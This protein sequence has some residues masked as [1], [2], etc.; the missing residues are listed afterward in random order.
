MDSA[1]KASKSAGKGKRPV[2]GYN[3]RNWYANYSNI[4]WTNR[5][6]ETCPKLNNNKLKK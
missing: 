5:I 4:A 1:K 2:V 3:F 6:Y